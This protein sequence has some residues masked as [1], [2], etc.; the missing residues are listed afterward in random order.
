MIASE[1]IIHGEPSGLDNTTSCY[2]GAVKFNRAAVSKFERFEKF[3]KIDILLTNTMVPR[4]TKVLVSKVRTF[5]ETMKNVAEPLLASIE[6][7]S[8]EVIDIF[9]RYMLL[10]YKCICIFFMFRYFNIC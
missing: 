8:K 3:P 2:G 5:Y 9:G 7:I 1:V 6:G 4:S 10:V